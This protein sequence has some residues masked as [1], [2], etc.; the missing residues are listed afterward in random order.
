M[1]SPD[2]LEMPKPA[3]MPRPVSPKRMDTLRKVKHLAA[4]WGVGLSTQAVCQGHECTAE[5]F[6]S[7]FVDRLPIMLVHGSRGSGKSYGAALCAHLDSQMYR[8][9]ATNILG[10]SLAQSSQIYNALKDFDRRRPD[11][12]P[13]R[14]FAKTRATYGN[15][16]E[17]MMLAASETSVHGP[18]V[19]R[20]FMDE[21]DEIDNS[22]RES[23]SGIPM[24]MNGVKASTVLL[25]TWHRVSGPM[26][27][28]IKKAGDGA[29]RLFTFCIFDVLER[30]PVERSGPKLENCPSCLLHKFCHDD[31]HLRADGLPKAKR[32]NGHYKIDDLI[33]KVNLYSL[34][35]FESDFLCT[36]PRS[37]GV[38]FT[39]FDDRIH[40]SEDAEYNPNY[41][42]H[43]SID[44]GVC[45]GAIWIQAH[46]DHLGDIEVS[47]F[48]DYYAEEKSA[49]DNAMAIMDQNYKFTGLGLHYAVVSIDPQANQKTGIGPTMRG[50][51]E[52]AGCVGRGGR[53][54]FWPAGIA[55]PK[56]D[57]LAL[58]EAL[59]QSASGRVRLK[60][61]P[62]CRH[63]RDAFMSYVRATREGQ[64]MDY[65]Q[66]PQHPAE[67]AIDAL[68]GGLKLEFPKG[69]A[70]KLQL[71]NIHASEV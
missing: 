24:E 10:G 69:R 59:L 34:R 64:L 12:S 57:A 54:K 70:P 18:H 62:R 65:P 71:R 6:A 55:H 60:I 22:I 66:D 7:M 61:H 36:R 39:E 52:R 44:P 38:W 23:A 9:H 53:L 15:G 21:V 31:R 43:L 46:E 14:S 56:Q 48:G 29:F 4:Q 30:C 42:F 35:V 63:L 1:T 58:I 26:A 32:S 25:S 45:T 3:W 28:L 16:S 19:P 47:V 51:Y 40:V 5:I 20:L 27:G 17:I 8:N 2:I 49:E 41:N 37:S 67:E 50:E 68:A 13:F 33:A 11:I